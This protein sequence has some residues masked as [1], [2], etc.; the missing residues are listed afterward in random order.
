MF[1]YHWFDVHRSRLKLLLL[2]FLV[3][4]T[5][6][7]EPTSVGFDIHPQT[8]RID[9]FH[10]DTVTVQVLT[11]A[12]DSIQTSQT[13]YNLVGSMNDP[14][15]GRVKA[16]FCTQ[17]L[18]PTANVVFPSNILIDSLVLS[19]EIKSYYGNNKSADLTTFRVYEN[20]TVIYYDSTY[21]SNT[22]LHK[23]QLLGVRTFRPNVQD[24][25][26]ID[27]KKYPPVIR[28]KLDNTLAKRLVEGSAQG[29]LLNNATFTE[30]FRGLI[31]ETDWLM[32]GG[33]IYYIDLISNFSNV[34]LYYRTPDN[35]QQKT[36]VFPIN[37]RAARFN[38]Y[39]I[40]RANASS[41][42]LQQLAAT[43]F[44]PVKRLFLQA[45]GSTKIHIH[46][47][48]IRNLARPYPIIVN[49]AELIFYVDQ[50]DFTS[51]TY[52]VPA[53][54]TLVKYKPDSTYTFLPDN[55]DP[56]FGGQYDDKT[57]S[58]R[59][60][61]TRHIQNLVRE[62]YDDYGIVLIV[63]GAASRADRVVLY[64][65]DNPKKPKLFITYSVVKD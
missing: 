46:F 1:F 15:F 54:L 19:L 56:T 28:I 18:L 9:I 62:G 33:M 30:F 35:S 8:D 16:S 14:V 37:N 10:T 20:G 26:L 57:K 39:E 60:V 55:N 64:G 58:Y 42:F 52:P 7:K 2:F 43:N 47:P 44:I 61:I 59:F 45:L 49:K 63:A 32:H 31:V 41:E 17:I 48:T 6:C 4:F 5:S 23:K 65:S 22:L 29:H 40:H 3:L 51:A 12:E 36:F 11:V 50:T 53:K 38:V 27:G 24:S 34:T 13:L 21:Y 25:V